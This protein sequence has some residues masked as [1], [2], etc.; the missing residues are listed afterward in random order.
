MAKLKVFVKKN[1][2][3]ITLVLVI[4]YLLS[5]NRP[6]PYTPL[7]R[8]LTKGSIAQE[9]ISKALPSGDTVSYSP[10]SI[11]E[12]VSSAPD[13]RMVAEDIYTS[14]K[15]ES[16]KDSIKAIKQNSESV[17]GFMVSSDY[18]NPKGS[19]SG[20]ISVRIPTKS[21]ENFLNFLSQ[22]S[23]K[24]VSL[25][26]NALD[27]TD[28]YTD[29]E[30]RLRILQENKTKL[31]S[32]M[33]SATNVEEL[34]NIQNSV[35][36]VQQQIEKLQGQQKYLEDITSTVKITIYLSTDEYSL[37]YTPN[38]AWRPQVVFKDSVRQVITTFRNIVDFAIWLAVYSIIWL[39][40]LLL[41]I[42]VWRKYLK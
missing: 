41:G 35:F 22:N 3:V 42:F 31:E 10:T 9:K 18:N 20:T 27:V 7:Y 23:V 1:W 12:S 39:P 19:S 24:V 6:Q 33:Q 11:N 13:N 28:Q 4:L 40:L 30:E 8:G 32:I 34:L 36:R 5:K 17:G 38:N 15:V 26:V 29:I 37:P 21:Q 2:V 16:V 25:N 14:L